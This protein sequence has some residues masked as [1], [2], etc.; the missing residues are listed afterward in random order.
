MDRSKEDSSHEGVFSRH[1]KLIGIGFV[2]VLVLIAA[3]VIY[4]KV[5]EAKKAKDRK[6]TALPGLSNSNQE[7][8]KAKDRKAL[9]AL[10]TFANKDTALSGLSNSLTIAESGAKVA[11][12]KTAAKLKTCGP[13]QYEY[14]G[15]CYSG[16]P[17]NT[18]RGRSVAMVPGMCVGKTAPSH[19]DPSRMAGMFGKCSNPAYPEL[20]GILPYA[21]GCY[22]K[23]PAGMTRSK[24]DDS[25][26]M[27]PSAISRMVG[28]PKCPAGTDETMGLCMPPCPKGYKRGV[29]NGKKL[30][31]KGTGAI[32]AMLCY[33]QPKKPSA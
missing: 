3:V 13:G 6:D 31:A 14:M 30:I 27:Y 15:V 4:T 1:K 28:M 29:V 2:I 8:K 5:S 26:C 12:V 11:P 9:A 19:R 23:C 33:S 20:V 10:R 21:G 17:A 7:A 32:D 24:T 16:C 18:T 25:L 22:T